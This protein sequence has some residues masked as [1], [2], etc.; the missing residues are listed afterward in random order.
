MT[1]SSHNHEPK[2]NEGVDDSRP[3]FFVS[4]VAKLARF[5]IVTAVV[6]ILLVGALGYAGGAQ[7]LSILLAIGVIASVIGIHVGSLL[8]LGQP[9]R[10]PLAWIAFSYI[11][12]IGAI[13]LFVYL[14]TAFAQPVRFPATCALI[15]IVVSQ[16]FELVALVRMRQFN[17]D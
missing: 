5:E 3:A 12:R 15:A 4:T 1:T 11:G 13:A 16:L 9:A 8:E 7:I 14:P 6:A 10:N 2:E 17:V